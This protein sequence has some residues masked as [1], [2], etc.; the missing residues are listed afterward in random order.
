MDIQDFFKQA[1]DEEAGK[2]ASDKT[3]DLERQV[4]ELKGKIDALTSPREVDMS[5]FAMPD[6][7]EL[8]ALS[9][10]GLPDPLVNEKEYQKALAARI[11]ANQL[12]NIDIIRR[13]DAE[14]AQVKS[15][16]SQ[17][18]D[19]LWDG[20]VEKYPDY[21]KY[22]KQ[23]EWAAN[24][25]IQDKGAEGIDVPGYVFGSTDSFYTDVLEEIKDIVPVATPAPAVDG[26]MGGANESFR[27]M[28][29]GGDAGSR[30]G[31]PVDAKPSDFIKDLQTLQRKDGFY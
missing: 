31:K 16:Q 3:S 4:S 8:I 7:P 9:L 25:V 24:K 30:G 15:N 17:R 6:A 22:R 10:E 18:V 5:A 12:E 29:M 19:G 13:H 26:G 28:V 14:V 2:K 11:Q 27:T 20:F 1:D 23:I 21:A